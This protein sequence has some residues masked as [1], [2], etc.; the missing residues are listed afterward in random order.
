MPLDQVMVPYWRGFNYGIGVRSATAGPLALAVEGA[1]SSVTGAAGGTA[2]FH[3]SRVQTTDDIETSLGISADVSG[4]VGLFSASDRFNFAR[5]CKVQT[6]SLSLV[7]SST[8]QK[9][10]QQ[11]D[12]PKLNSD[13]GALVS[14]G[15]LDEFAAR[16]G[17]MFV[18]GVQTGGQFFGIFRIDAKTESSRQTIDNAL[19]GSYGPFSG[20]THFNL[21]Q[22]CMNEH[23]SIYCD[24]YIEGGKVN[25]QP[26]TPDNLLTAMH[27]WATT[28]DDLPVSY[29]VS[30]APYIIA[31]GPVPPNVIDLQH[32]KDVLVQCARLRSQTLDKLNLVEYV[33]DPTHTAEFSGLA[34][35]PDLGA[36]HAGLSSDLDVIAA[37]ASYA[38]DNPKS[39]VDP[40]T[41]ARTKIV[42]ADGTVM[43]PGQPDYKLTVL[44]N[45]PKHE[46]A[47]V[48]VPNFMGLISADQASQIAAA[49]RLTIHWA[50]DGQVNDTFQIIAQDPRPAT[51][52]SPGAT[53]TLTT[54]LSSLAWRLRRKP[55]FLTVGMAHS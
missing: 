51:P 27:E 13:A 35:G 45:M 18:R 23:A 40:E 14:A 7:V 6:T 17:D 53:V 29:F 44:P 11:I 15:K 42:A 43:R 28:V 32:Q 46:G 9:A 19:A 38:L 24:A 47:T 3:L 21:V 1:L 22:T 48:M 4:G 34:G 20:D 31:L 5:D 36:L 8:R 39:A 41:F 37:A 16:Y 30:L 50:D 26:N 2:T 33:M 55:A 12:A 25:T 49:N 10:F 52:V 54:H